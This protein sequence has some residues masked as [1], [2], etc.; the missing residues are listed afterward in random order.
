[1]A[2]LNLTISAQVVGGLQVSASRAKQIE[3]YDKIDVVIEPGAT[4]IK[5][6]IQPGAA[7]QVEFLLIKSSLYSQEPADQK[8]TYFVGDGVNDFPATVGGLELDDPHI[9]VGGALAVFG[10]DPKTLRFNSTYVANPTNPT[11]NRAVVE[12]LVGRNAIA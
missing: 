5:V 12:I 9:Y 8:L 11:V 3:A 4:D 2:S 10:L 7:N 1:M 6:D